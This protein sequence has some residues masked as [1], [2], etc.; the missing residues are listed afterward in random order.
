[1]VKLANKPPMTPPSRQRG[2]LFPA[3]HTSSA[4]VASLA[5]E[6]LFYE[7]SGARLRMAHRCI[8]W[9]GWEEGLLESIL[10]PEDQEDDWFKWEEQGPDSPAAANAE[11]Y[12]LDAMASMITLENGHNSDGR[13]G[14]TDGKPNGDDSK[15]DGKSEGTGSTTSSSSKIGP[16]PDGKLKPHGI[17]RKKLATKV[18]EEEKAKEKHLG[19]GGDICGGIGGELGRRLEAW[20]HHNQ[21][22]PPVAW[23]GIGTPALSRTVSFGE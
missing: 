5:K 17:G 4:D 6:W 8:E 20:L 10:G 21:H 18:A 16:V 7:E 2:F 14:V 22:T 19:P 9:D 13:N 23:S 12:G 3:P 15:S 1:V 11:A